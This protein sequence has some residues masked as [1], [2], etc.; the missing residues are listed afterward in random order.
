MFYC[1]FP[2]YVNEAEHGL[3]MA[4]ITN[5]ITMYETFVLDM[6]PSVCLYPS[7]YLPRV[8]YVDSSL[9]KYDESLLLG[10]GTFGQVY[11]GSYQ[12]TPA[13][14]KRILLGGAKAEE[15]DILH[16]I[17]VSVRIFHLNSF[18]CALCKLL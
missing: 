3:N 6:C 17:N 8:P 11:R 15:K 9:I 10:Q 4:P 2:I 18:F 7:V 5:P 13:A 16:E 14:V 1:L 12:G